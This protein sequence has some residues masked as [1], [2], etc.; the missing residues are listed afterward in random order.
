MDPQEIHV[1]EV[2]VRGHE[3][4]VIALTVMVWDHLITLEDERQLF[5]KRRPWTLATFFFLWN[6]YVGLI[7]AIFGVIVA[8]WPNPSD[9]VGSSWLLVEA[10]LGVSISWSAQVIL[11][12]RIY[13]LYDASP[14]IRAILISTFTVEVL[15]AIVVFGVASA[16]NKFKVFAETIASLVRCNATVI[17]SWLWVFWLAV[18]SFEFLLCVLAIYKGYHRVKSIGPQTLH[19]ILVRDSVMFYLAIQVIYACNLISWVNHPKI[20]LDLTTGLAIALPS[21][22]SNRMLINVRHA[23]YAPNR[24]DSPSDISLEEISI[25]P[26]PGS[27]NPDND[28]NLIT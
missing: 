21:V 18:A 23:L 4:R 9:S 13:A 1:W 16:D 17:P 11:Q 10:W 7:L 12:L 20:T 3:N 8:L 15:T 5:W 27:P 24:L 6:R 14:Q 19:H 28:D 2:A 25:R 22:L 26:P